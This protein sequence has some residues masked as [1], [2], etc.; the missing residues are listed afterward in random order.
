M[1]KLAIV[2]THPDTRN[3]APFDDPDV[4][5]WVFNESA[6]TTPEYYPNDPDKQWCKRWDAVLQLHKKEVYA[7][8]TNWVNNRHWEWL[9]REHGPNKTIWMQEHDNQVPNCKKYPLDEILATV[10]G[11]RYKWFTSTPSYAVALG[12]YLGYKDIGLYGL[13]M[14]S[15]TEYGYQLLNFVFWVGVCEGLGINLFH[16]SNKRYFSEKLYG[17]EGEIQIQRDYFVKRKEELYGAWQDAEKMSNKLRDRVSDYLL[18]RKYDKLVDT[19]L[20]WR[21]V[22]IRA[23]KLSGAEQE[24]IN[25]SQREDMI[26]RQQ[27]E[28]R[29]AEAAKQGEE[30]KA[31][32]YVLAGK[33]EYTF[34]AWKQS[35][36]F[37]ALQQLRLFIQQQM[38]MAYNVGASNGAYQENL[39]YIKEYDDLLQAAGG[40]RTLSALTGGENAA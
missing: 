1:K 19:L 17:Y 15:N 30:Q 20:A 28:R 5:I 33:T 40:V 3:N 29:A 12:I 34:N 9:Q 2:G 10:P 13:D 31:L 6:Q 32:M 8:P 14:N 23:G 11:A 27:F 22:T 35:G 37:E 18:E 7:S 16:V 24:A 36:N 4:D 26:S 25:Y 21:E 38:Q 39:E